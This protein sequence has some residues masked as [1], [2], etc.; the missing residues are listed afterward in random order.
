MMKLFDVFIVKLKEFV[1]LKEKED[2]NEKK[3]VGYNMW[4]LIIV[5]RAYCNKS[6]GNIQNVA[7]NELL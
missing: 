3:C 4:N 2:F 5:R 6:M 1:E 7:G